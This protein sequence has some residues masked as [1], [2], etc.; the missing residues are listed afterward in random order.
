MSELRFL[1]TPVGS[2][3]YANALTATQLAALLNVSD[4]SESGGGGT[5]GPI[6]GT[7]ATTLVGAFYG[8]G[9]LLHADPAVTIASGVVTA[10]SF[11]GSGAGLTAVPAASLTGT[12]AQ[13]RLPENV[14]YFQGED[15]RV[16]GLLTLDSTL[17]IQNGTVEVDDQGVLKAASISFGGGAITNS[18]SALAVTGDVSAGSISSGTFT[19]DAQFQG[20]I[21]VASDFSCDNGAVSTNGAGLLSAV[22]LVVGQVSISCGQLT[23]LASLD[24]GGSPAATQSYVDSA[25]SGGVSG[26]ATTSYVDS[27]VS[28]ATSG[29]ASQSYADNAVNNYS[30]QMHFDG[31]TIT[32]NGAADMLVGAADH[33][34]KV[35]VA[36]TTGTVQITLD[37]SNGNVTAVRFGDNNGVVVTAGL[38]VD[39]YGTSLDNGAITTD[40][41]GNLVVGNNLTAVSVQVGS[42]SIGADGLVIE[43]GGTLTVAAGLTSLDGGAIATD[44]SGKLTVGSNTTHR[45]FIEVRG[46]TTEDSG[47]VLYLYRYDDAIAT[48]TLDGGTGIASF[49]GG[50]ITTDGSGNITAA[51]L[52]VGS[53]VD[54]DVGRLANFGGT[55]PVVRITTTEDDDRAT[56]ELW[57]NPNGD[58]MSV[59]ADFSN[60]QFNFLTPGGVSFYFE[61]G[62]LAAASL[63]PAAS[64]FAGETRAP[65]FVATAADGTK[66][67][68]TAG[69][70][71]TKTKTV[72]NKALT[73][74][75][76]TLTTSTAHGFV[77]GETV[78]VS[79]IGSP[80]DGTYVVAST[81]TS[82]TFTYAKTNA[83][84]ASASSS[85]S[86]VVNQSAPVYVVKNG[87]GTAVLGLYADGVR[88]IGGNAR[89]ANATDLQTS[90]SAGG[91]VASGTA[92]V[93]GG[94]TGNAASGNYAAVCG[95]QGVSATGANSFVGGGFN[96]GASQTYSVVCGGSANGASSPYAFVGG[97]TGNTASGNYTTV[98][99]GSGNS[100]AGFNS[101]VS[102][103]QSNIVSDNYSTVAGGASNV[104][105]NTYAFIG[106]GQGN[107]ATATQTT[108]AGGSNNVATASGA[109]VSGGLF[110]NA[111]GTQAAVVGGQGN[112][113]GGACSVVGGAN[114][115]LNSDAVG[116]VAFGNGNTVGH[117][118]V[119]AQGYGGLSRANFSTVHSF[120][121]AAQAGTYTGG[122]AN[123]GSGATLVGPV[124]CPV[125]AAQ[126]VDGLIAVSSG[127]QFA[128]VSV[129][130]YVYN[131]GSGL[132]FAL[133]QNVDFHNFS[134][135]P[136]FAIQD[137]GSGTWFLNVDA[138][139][140][141][142]SS[143]TRIQYAVTLRSAEAVG[144][145]AAAS[146]ASS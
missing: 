77:V 137:T 62:G 21:H 73:S 80:F 64:V 4:G 32:S 146:G 129:K 10:T 39:A 15:F 2:A 6:D 66:T 94:G 3:N 75:V 24:L 97:G 113:A 134:S 108:I 103:G 33:P 138:P 26:F 91:Q 136:T 132:V 37:G 69:G 122:S 114:N 107:Q 116:S 120:D 28:S 131:T 47:G 74:N 23:G 58:G 143:P 121:A 125:G 5:A 90:R 99:G 67:P 141:D 135:A 55:T 145:P 128:A 59:Q 123:P 42:A 17:S 18:G 8:L 71:P 110:N 13:A 63:S 119:S 50:A 83:N 106:G 9:G 127:N 46:N 104:A 60:G 105:S 88:S 98:G 100:A 49:D 126:V 115:V 7:T 140:V 51:G 19:S 79:G 48:I 27:V 81:P 16:T 89:G 36:D 29:L 130:F 112:Q 139:A 109:T 102:G 22:G 30:G 133:T 118:F 41:S 87:A 86:A 84:V 20:N 95:G 35:R 45:G 124:N 96:N 56:L 76:V 38:Q 1:P 117:Q 101:V 12:V 57:S 44:G 111:A 92:S 40:G 25:I 93:I 70:V 52:L 78:V 54:L 144:L 82:T 53:G 31:Q 65:S 11:S 34:G 61:S 142:G 72:S 14:A 43:D 68:V 85:G